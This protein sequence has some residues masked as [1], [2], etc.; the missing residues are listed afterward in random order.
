MSNKTRLVAFANG[1]SNVSGP[2]EAVINGAPPP[3]HCG[4][5]RALALDV[6]V[7]GLNPMDAT[8]RSVPHYITH[9]AYKLKKQGGNI[10]K[11]N[12][13]L[14]TQLKTEKLVEDYIR[15]QKLKNIKNAAVVII[16]N[17][18]HKIITYVGSANFYDT[19]DG[20]QVNGADAVRQPGSQ[21]RAAPS[22]TATRC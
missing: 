9:L 17:K 4:F 7:N 12:I 13:D 1:Y 19:T 15:I 22:P 21:P 16:D 3:P 10:I 6:W 2:Q 20:G 18:T 14:N 8:R 11:T 5:N